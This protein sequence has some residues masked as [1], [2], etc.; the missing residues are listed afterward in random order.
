MPLYDFECESCGFVFERLVAASASAECPS[1]ASSLVKRLPSA[2]AVSSAATRKAHLQSARKANKE[3]AKDKQIAD[4]EAE[5]KH[6]H[7]H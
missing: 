6:H 3:A 4:R 2:F 7:D 1:C 5:H